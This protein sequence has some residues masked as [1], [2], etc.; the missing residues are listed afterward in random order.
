VR[1]AISLAVVATLAITLSACTQAP[2]D[3]QSSP[4]S[5]STSAPASALDECVASGA[6]SDAVTVTGDFGAKP[7]V[8]FATPLT[9][10]TTERTVVIEGEGEP[11]A[12][13]ATASIDFS[14]YNATTGVEIDQVA[15]PYDGASY[16]DF[17]VSE[18]GILLGMAKTVLCSTVGSRVVGVIP[19]ADSWGDAG[20]SDLGVAAT[21]S[22]V[23]VADIVAIK[24]PL[25]PEAYA[26]MTDAPAVV[27]DD[28]GVPTITIPEGV[29][30]PEVTRIGIISAGDG[31]VVQPGASV[32][33]NYTGV[34]W[35][36]GEVFDSSFERGTP[37]T[38]TTTGVVT[39]FRLALEGMTVG[40]KMLAIIAPEDGYGA[41][42]S[43]GIPAN[44]ALVFVVDIVSVG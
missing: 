33:V 16:A 43:N 7:T 10:E 14:I 15:T 26:D 25:V 28:A 6:A 17:P 2:A 35:D 1:T 13:G 5:S 37:A 21:D 27:F 32:T 11:A 9:A 23:F 4:S 19:P 36:T 38:F 31:E 18:S 30:A 44:A 42:G 8:E 40:S 39:G 29:A 34:L 20:Q 24:P 22:L 3:T 41:T 12:I